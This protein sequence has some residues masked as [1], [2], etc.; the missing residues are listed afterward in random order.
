MSKASTI[1]GQS[2]RLLL[3]RPEDSDLEAIAALWADPAATEH[4]GGPRDRGMILDSFRQYAADPDTFAQQE[5]ERWWSIVER[6]SGALIGLCSLLEKE[7]AGQIET[8][9]GYYLLP[10][11]W[12]RGYATEAAHLVVEHAFNALQLSS[13]VAIIH[14]QNAASIA[15][16]GRLGMWLEREVPRPDGVVRQ[17]YRLRRRDPEWPGIRSGQ[18]ASPEKPR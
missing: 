1:L 4:I 14:P 9:I 12:G 3:R 16:A 8:E 7:V 10:A 2:K 15:V 13:L 18:T 6:S 17:V 5:G 11:H